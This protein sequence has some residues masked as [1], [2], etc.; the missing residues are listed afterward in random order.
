VCD[1]NPPPAPADVVRARRFELIDDSGRVRAV[2]GNLAREGD[3]AYWPGLALRDASG[4]DRVSLMV[5][6]L[7]PEL[8]YDFGVNIV[9]VLGVLD[10]GTEGP[11]PGVN[12]TVFD[13][14]GRPVL[15]WH[16]N[17]DGAVDFRGP[18]S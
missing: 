15:G 4:R 6:N 3:D 12:L 2:L 10:P 17:A 11:V 16:G 5:H 14:D 9:I 8:A 18:T 1:R 7:G 13:A